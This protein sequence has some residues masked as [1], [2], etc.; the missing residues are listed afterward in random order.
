MQP[1][2]GLWASSEEQKHGIKDR[3]LEGELE[4]QNTTQMYKQSLS[5]DVLKQ[6]N[7][8]QSF[9]QVVGSRRPDQNIDKRLVNEYILTW[10]CTV[11]LMGLTVST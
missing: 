3:K 4:L 8:H 6:K 1:A 11:W 9:V 2:G 10:I 7:L 5:S